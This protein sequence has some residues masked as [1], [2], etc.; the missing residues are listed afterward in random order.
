MKMKEILDIVSGKEIYVNDPH[1][2]DIDFENAFGTDLMSD[3]LCHLRDADERELLITDRTCKYANIPHCK[4][5]GFSCH[6]D[7]KRENNR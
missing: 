1:V 4:H 2:Y 6:I 5:T 3:A 7:C